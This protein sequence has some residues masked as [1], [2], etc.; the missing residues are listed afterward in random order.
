MQYTFSNKCFENII[1]VCGGFS[2]PMY[3]HTWRWPSLY[4]ITSHYSCTLCHYGANIKSHLSQGTSWAFTLLDGCISAFTLCC[5]TYSISQILI[6]EK[7]LNSMDTCTKKWTV[8]IRPG[9][10][11]HRGYCSDGS[12]VRWTEVFKSDIASSCETWFPF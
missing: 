7:N 5:L 2:V 3:C 12:A 1:Y 6:F 8:C 4:L 11:S 9:L 10:C